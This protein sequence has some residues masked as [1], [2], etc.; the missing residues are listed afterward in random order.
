MKQQQLKHKTQT[1]CIKTLNSQ[2]K[3]VIQAKFHQTLKKHQQLQA[4]NQMPLARNKWQSKDKLPLE[5][6]GKNVW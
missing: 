3:Q 5:T 6:N 2:Q 4:S 1:I